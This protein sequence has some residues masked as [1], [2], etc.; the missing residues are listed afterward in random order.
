MQRLYKSIA[1]ESDVSVTYESLSPE[2]EV[3]S[4]YGVESD[5]IIV[6]NHGGR[7]TTEIL[8]EKTIRSVSKLGE[9]AELFRG[10]IKK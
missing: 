4:F 8:S 5:I 1:I 3:K 9:D 10:A 6:I 7:K 2:V